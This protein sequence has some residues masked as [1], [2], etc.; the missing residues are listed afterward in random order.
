MQKGAVLI[1]SQYRAHREKAKRKYQAA[2][3]IQNYYRRY[4]KRKLG[5]ED[6]QQKIRL[7]QQADRKAN[8]YLKQSTT[9]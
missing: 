1:Q 6:F 4:R 2:S 3:V 5:Q 9:R 8:R 7:Q